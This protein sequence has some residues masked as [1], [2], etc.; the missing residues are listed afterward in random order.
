MD[1][2]LMIGLGFAIA[3]L[4]VVVIFTQAPHLVGVTGR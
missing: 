1:L 2:K 3:G 4:A